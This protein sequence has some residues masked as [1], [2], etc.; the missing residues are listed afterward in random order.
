MSEAVWHLAINGQTLGPLTTEEIKARLT[1]GEIGPE[2][3]AYGPGSSQWAPIKTVPGL[4][5]LLGPAAATAPPPPPRA[6]SAGADQIDYRVEGQEMQFVEV[7]LDPGESAVAE[8][9]AMLYMTP[10]VAMQTIFGDGRGQAQARGILDHLIGAG[11]RLLTGESL[12]MTLFT[13]AGAAG[14]ER[15]AFAAP[16]A[17]KILPLHL[18]DLDGELICQ[19]DSFLCAAR[20]VALEIAFQKRIGVGLFGGEGFIMQRLMGDGWVFLH[21]GGTV[22]E[23][24]LKAGETLKVDTGC[25]VALMP[26]VDYDVE[27]V[28]GVKTALFGGEGLFFARLTGPGH[29]WLQSLPLSRLADRIYAAAKHGGGKQK[30]EGSILPGGLDA[31]FGKD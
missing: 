14:K 17:G 18:K 16:Y 13:H 11:K 29:V 6:A 9:G 30:G 21:A 4:A 20:G 5:G 31:F 8:A 10:G 27:F 24:E 12:F 28:G 3:W 25:L 19:K 23:Y 26:G 22:F 2:T 15:V 1:R 7:E